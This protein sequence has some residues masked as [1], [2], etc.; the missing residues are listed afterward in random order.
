M[1]GLYVHIPFCHRKCTYCG[2]YSTAGQHDTEGY[3]NALCREIEQNAG[4]F[5]KSNRPRRTLYFGGGTPTL[6]S[7]KQLERIVRC[8]DQHFSLSHL[9]EM[10]IEANPENLTPDYLE[11][12][13]RLH[14]N[15]ISIGVQSFNDTDLKTLNR[16][17]NARQALRAIEMA[18]QAGFGNISIDL[19]YGLP[20][21]SV[22]SWQQLLDQVSS[23]SIQHL[24]CYALTIEEGT[25]LER[26]IQTGRLHP[27]NE[28][29]VVAQYEAL[30]QWA[31]QNGFE[32]YE[33]SNF[34]QHGYPSIHNSRYWRREPYLG[35]GPAAHTFDGTNRRC[36]LPDTKRYI[37]GECRY[38]WDI[39]TEEDAYNETVILGLRTIEGIAKADIP[40]RWIPSLAQSLR[41]YIENNLVEET[42]THFKPTHNGLLRADGI[43]ADIIQ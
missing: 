21:Q 33:I 35:L 6:L 5:C 42:A 8:L 36:T 30:C 27:T 3:V 37:D 19:I 32:Q 10:T 43:A 24:S 34:C 39:L 20:S 25:M 9:E 17:H 12:L 1:A 22:D 16:S 15:R 28:E 14:F 18:R 26:Q 13:L 4:F 11:G 41:P 29:T 7:L 38:T 2:F 40:P 31:Q 23:L